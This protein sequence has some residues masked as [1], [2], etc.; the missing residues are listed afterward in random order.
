MN[1][2]RIPS[3]LAYYSKLLFFLPEI[4]IHAPAV[5]YLPWPTAIWPRDIIWLTDIWLTDILPKDIL[6]TDIWLTDI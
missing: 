3:F 2:D 5:L 6:P 1:S 4:F